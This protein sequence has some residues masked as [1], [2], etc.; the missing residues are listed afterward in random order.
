MKLY[1]KILLL[2]ACLLVG[3]SSNVQAQYVQEKIDK[4]LV[5]VDTKS[6]K[7]FYLKEG[8]HV[9]LIKLNNTRFEGACQILDIVNDTIIAN[10][11]IEPKGAKRTLKF[12]INN[13]DEIHFN[14]DNRQVIRGIATV[15]RY[16]F[17]T[18]PLF[19]LIS[20][21]LI[22]SYKKKYFPNIPQSCSVQIEDYEN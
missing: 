18:G 6:N 17:Q 21:A 20:L 12:A 8:R 1:S 9:I 19:P 4:R 5:F 10:S 15:M 14:P 22:P 3:F 16:S 7:K 11:K 13:I 2:F